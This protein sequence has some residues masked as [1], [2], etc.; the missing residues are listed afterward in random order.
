[1]A[2]GDRNV[3]ALTTI[4]TLS[5]ACI[6]ASET[7]RRS[8]RRATLHSPYASNYKHA[9]THSEMTGRE[10]WSPLRKPFFTVHA[11]SKVKIIGVICEEGTTLWAHNDLQLLGVFIIQTGRMHM[12]RADRGVHIGD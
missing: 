1:M 12:G 5:T 6:A 4:D 7:R 11:R 8:L 9:V 3:V 10:K 2:V